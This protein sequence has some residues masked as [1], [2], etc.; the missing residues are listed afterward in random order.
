MIEFVEKQIN[1][2]V[3]GQT[4]LTAYMIPR[5]FNRKNRSAIINISHNKHFKP[6]S[7]LP[8]LSAAKSYCHTLSQA[9]TNAYDPA[10]LDVMTV[11]PGLVR[12]KGMPRY[13]WSIPPE[14]HAKAVIDQLGRQK[15]TRGYYLHAL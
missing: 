6:D 9:M 1:V 3:N 5:L 12:L 11:T 14:T 2:N 10:K 4:Y 15:E 7:N 8:V 13:R